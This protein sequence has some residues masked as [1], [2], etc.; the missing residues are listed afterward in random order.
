MMEQQKKR[1][2]WIDSLKVFAILLM[3]WGHVLPRLGQYAPLSMAERFNGINGVIY[4][5]H[6]PLFMILSGYVSSKLIRRQGDVL[7]KFRQLIV[8]CISLFF[9]CLIVG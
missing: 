7:R 1:I 5:F 4:S 9:I 6:M 2:L 8:P 3:V